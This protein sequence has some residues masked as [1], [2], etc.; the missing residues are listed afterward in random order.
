MWFGSSKVVDASGRPLVVYH[1]GKTPFI[2]EFKNKHGVHYF[3]PNLAHAQL[4]AM[5]HGHKAVVEAFVSLQNPFVTTDSK[6]SHRLTKNQRQA[7]IDKGF[8][9]VIYD[10]AQFGEV[11][12]F[13][14][15][16]IKSAQNNQ[17]SF[18]MENSNIFDAKKRAKKAIDFLTAGEKKWVN[19]V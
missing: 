14:P 13:Y 12:A 10:D 18:D 2:S 4:F 16:Q 1:G 6:E 15:G 5:E 17:G 8:D 19:R 3:S 11:V 9:G 7:L